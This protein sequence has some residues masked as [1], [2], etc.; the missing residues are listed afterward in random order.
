[1]TKK[2]KKRKDEANVI[3]EISLVVNVNFETK[4]GEQKFVRFIVNSF[5]CT[6]FVYID[7]ALNY[8]PGLADH[9]FNN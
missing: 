9:F 3:Y 8:T 1:M 4:N 5:I 2:K 6:S 7:F